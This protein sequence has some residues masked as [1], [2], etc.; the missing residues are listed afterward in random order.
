MSEE[1]MIEIVNRI[2][3]RRIELGMSY[4]DLA[5]KTGMSKSTLQRYETGAI[6]SI[7]LDKLEDLANALQMDPAFLVGF[8]SAEENYYLD[9]EVA[10]MA[11]EMA[12]RPEMQIM[13]DA[14]RNL[15]KEDIE[16]VTALIEKMSKK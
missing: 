16:I 15:T 3:S 4:Q 1:K 10:Q 5:E 8:P 11:Q 12:T 13:F 9:P 7:P 6:R 2:K 14:S